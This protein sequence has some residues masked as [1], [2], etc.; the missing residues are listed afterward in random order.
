LNTKIITSFRKLVAEIGS[1]ES[2]ELEI[3]PIEVNRGG[4]LGVQ[5]HYGVNLRVKN[6][7]KETV[8]VLEVFDSQ[9][10]NCEPGTIDILKQFDR[11]FKKGAFEQTQS[12][13][14]VDASKPVEYALMALG[15]NP[16]PSNEI[17]NGPIPIIREDGVGI[18]EYKIGSHTVKVYRAYTGSYYRTSFIFTDYSRKDAV[19]GYNDEIG[20]Q[21]CHKE[22]CVFTYNTQVAVPVTI[23]L[24]QQ[25]Y[26]NNFN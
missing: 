1:S 19:I 18:W 4:G 22:K 11:L 15:V 20:E 7:I 23:E 21:P 6:V 17:S 5:E 2:L 16:T 9:F 3:I 14:Y 26:D 13:V 24:L 25:I 10:P 12:P 8:A